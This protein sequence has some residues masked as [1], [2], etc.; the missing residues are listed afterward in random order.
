MSGSGTRIGGDTPKQFLLKGGKPL[1]LYTVEA[2]ERHKKIDAIL[3]VTS[4]SYIDVVKKDIYLNKY[5]KVID[6]IA[7]GDKRHISCFKALCYLRENYNNSNINVL[8]HDG[9]RCNV[10][11]R[12]ISR[13]VHELKKHNAVLTAIRGK[14]QSER[15]DTYHSFKGKDYLA[16]TPQS[17]KFN[18]IYGL[19]NIY[20]SRNLPEITDEIMLCELLNSCYS[21]VKG[22]KENYKIT[23]KTDLE[24]FLKE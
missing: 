15:I 11:E 6:V 2:F 23:H 16:Q 4:S 21:I 14:K 5:R 8:I 9:V 18:L 13:N 20:F 10:S 24:K 12:I 7:G 1:Y 19:Y 22:D 3:L 17:F